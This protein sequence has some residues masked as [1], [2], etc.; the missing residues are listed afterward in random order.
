MGMHVIS[1]LGKVTFLHGK[2]KVMFRKV[3]SMTAEEE[4]AQCSVAVESEGR[5]VKTKRAA[6]SHEG[7]VK[8]DVKWEAEPFS[9][10]DEDFI[11]VV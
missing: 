5:G 10:E 8:E 7:T 1:H 2:Q 3:P 6:G 4:K 11:T 9:I